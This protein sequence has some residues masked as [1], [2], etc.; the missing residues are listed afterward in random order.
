VV[1]LTDGENQWYDHPSGGTG[2]ANNAA[3]GCGGLSNCAPGDGD[4]SAYGRLSEQRLG[5]GIDTNGEA[6]PEINSRMSALCTAMKAKNI[7]I[8][9]IVVET[10]GETVA[11]LYRNCAS[12]PE[13]YFNAPSSTELQAIFKKI[14]TQLSNLRLSQ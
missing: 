5:A 1:L 2:N 14:A 3:P 10:A 9:T 6:L 4:Y 7:I 13:Y 11:N 8:Y 12:K